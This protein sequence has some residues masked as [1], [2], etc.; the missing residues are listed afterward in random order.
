[1]PFKLIKGAFHLVGKTKTG[2]PLG[3]RPDGDS[4]QFKPAKQSHLDKLEQVGRPYR[5]STID[6][7]NLRFEGIDAPELHYD[8][9]RQPAPHAENSRNFL[10]GR[11][12]MDPVT[13]T[14]KGIQVKPPANDG[15]RGFIVSKQLDMHGRPVSFVFVGAHPQ[16]DGT[17]VFLSPALLR[18]SLNYQSLRDGHAYPLFYDTLYHDLRAELTGAAVTARANKR[19]FWPSDRSK[20]VTINAPADLEDRFL[21]LPK[22]FRRLT[23]YFQ[24]HSKLDAA[25]FRNWLEEKS[26]NDEVWILPEWNRTHFDNVVRIK[27]KKIT[28]LRGPENLVFVSRR[29]AGP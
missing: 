25:T 29:R 8:S 6:S 1:M 28:L 23:D 17:E 10:T 4:I 11:I 19:G 22:L 24:D 13:Y 12:G 3:F 18:Q 26:E 2:K 9:S 21:I 15:Q 20:G 14:E 27:G 5:L 7:V 16:P